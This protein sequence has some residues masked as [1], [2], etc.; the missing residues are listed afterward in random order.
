MSPVHVHLESPKERL[1]NEIVASMPARK[2]F[3]IRRTRGVEVCSSIGTPAGFEK[4]TSRVPDPWSTWRFFLAAKPPSKAARSGSFAE[5]RS[6]SFGG[7]HGQ[8]GVRRVAFFDDEIENDAAAAGR[9][10]HLVP[11]VSLS[12]ILDDDIGMRLEE[13]DEL[14]GRWNRLAIQNASLGLIDDAFYE[15]QKVGQGGNEAECP[16]AR[17]LLQR[18]FRRSHGLVRDLEQILVEWNA[19][20]HR[21]RVKNRDGSSLRTS[22]VIAAR[23]AVLLVRPQERARE[24]A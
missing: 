23:C 7:A 21:A 2:R 8:S 6:V 19:L 15:R 5:E 1:R 14:L 22:S 10:R 12:P 13:A 16:A 24:H 4:Q 17:E 18:P 3:R 9:E 20:G 11:V